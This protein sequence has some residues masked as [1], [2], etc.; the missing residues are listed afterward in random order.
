MTM[1]L[2]RTQQRAQAR[3]EKRQTQT[4]RIHPNRIQYAHNG[5]CVLML[6]ENSTNALA[7]TAEGVDDVIEK[8]RQVRDDLLKQKAANG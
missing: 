7:F 1:I 3:A 4:V 8:L 2:N 5:E 6:M